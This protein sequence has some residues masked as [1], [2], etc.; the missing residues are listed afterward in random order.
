MNGWDKVISVM[1]IVL[2]VG[3]F[4]IGNSGEALTLAVGAMLYGR[5]SAK[6]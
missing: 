1:L 2:A 6:G 4:T 5:I 3:N